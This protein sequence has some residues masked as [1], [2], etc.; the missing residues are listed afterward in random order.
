MVGNPEVIHFTGDSER[1]LVV[2]RKWL[3]P[4]TPYMRNRKMQGFFGRIVRHDQ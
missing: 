1:V 2:L 3:A 4:G